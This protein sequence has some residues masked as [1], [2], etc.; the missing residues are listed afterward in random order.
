MKLLMIFTVGAYL[1]LASVPATAD[2][3]EDEASI[4]SA[5]KQYVAAFN[6]HDAM[7]I[8][9]LVDEDCETWEGDIKGRAAMEETY[10]DI[11]ANNEHVQYKLTDE[12]GIVFVT[13]EVAIYKHND[14]ITGALD[15]DGKPL[16]PIKRLSAKLFVKK[17]GS[18]LWAAHFYRRIE[19]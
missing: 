19:E 8:A 2:Q 6:K 14:E 1:L 16:P 17:N 13:P 18:W 9:A 10:V 4:R 15:A 3:A 12:I 5:T 7:A 11:F